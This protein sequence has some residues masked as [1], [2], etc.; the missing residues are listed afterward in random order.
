MNKSFKVPEK[1]IQF[2]AQMKL[3]GNSVSKQKKA[4]YGRCF[5]TINE[6][7]TTTVLR[8]ICNYFDFELR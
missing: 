2:E 6:T 4:R 7:I 3:E 5:C 8:I 1:L